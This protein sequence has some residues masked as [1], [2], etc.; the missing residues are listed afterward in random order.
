MKL[1]CPALFTVCQS[2]GRWCETRN[3]GR[4]NRRYFYSQFRLRDFIAVEQ[5]RTLTTKQELEDENYQFFV[6]AQTCTEGEA[7][8]HRGGVSVLWLHE[9]ATCT[10][11]C[12]DAGWDR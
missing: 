9:T 10:G 7:C 2:T 1:Y 8:F 4:N 3:G 6:G 12:F 5:D 11:D